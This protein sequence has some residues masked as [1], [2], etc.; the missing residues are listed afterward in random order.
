MTSLTAPG[1]NSSYTYDE[2]GQR[3]LKVEGG[4]T[5]YYFFPEYEEQVAGGTTSSVNYYFMNGTRVAQST[6]TEGV[7]YYHADHL[8][9]AVKITDNTGAVILALAY[10][11][12][13]E[14]A[15]E[16]GSDGIRYRY[17]DQ[18]KEGIADLYYYDT[19]YYDTRLGR[20]LSQDS[21]LDGLNRY[22]YCYNNPIKYTDPTGNDVSNPGNSGYDENGNPEQ[23]ASFKVARNEDATLM[24]VTTKPGNACTRAQRVSMDKHNSAKPKN[25]TVI[26]V[27]D[28]IVASYMTSDDLPLQ[29]PTRC[30]NSTRKNTTTRGARTSCNKFT[31]Y[32]LYDLARNTGNQDPSWVSPGNAFWNYI[33]QGVSMGL[34]PFKNTYGVVFIFYPNT[35]RSADL[36][37]AGERYA[38]HPDPIHVSGYEYLSGD[39]YSLQWTT[40]TS[41]ITTETFSIAIDTQLH[42]SSA[43]VFIPFGYLESM[44]L[45]K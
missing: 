34:A 19:R 9:S 27:V 13:E 23:I 6:A 10:G 4:V 28:G 39:E 32:W 3:T 29:F 40:G 42:G 36:K 18:E 2:A 11:P 41:S 1:I 5:T 44:E 12:C 43:M 16:L 14:D 37:A 22:A 35:D 38:N 33:M 17:T 45:I 8:G 20:F 31:W 24:V 7:E 30:L 26:I 21:I 15:F 25:S